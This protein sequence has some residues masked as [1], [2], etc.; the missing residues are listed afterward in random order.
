[1]KK[2]YS[3]LLITM[4][5][6]S[7]EDKQCVTCIA[8]SNKGKIIETRS[9]CDESPKYLDGFTDGFKEKHQQNTNDSIN[10]HCTYTQ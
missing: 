9:A 2:L 1:M 6:T 3:L 10:V 4:L 8:E 7:C 5:I